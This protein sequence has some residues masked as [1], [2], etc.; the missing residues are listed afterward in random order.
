[1]FV[2]D[3]EKNS[4]RD[5]HTAQTGEQLAAIVQNEQVAV[6]CTRRQCR[7]VLPD[8]ERLLLLRQRQRVLPDNE[9]RRPVLSDTEWLWRELSDNERLR[10][11]ERVLRRHGT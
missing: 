7:R 8:N 9:R 5:G 3:A 4:A 6:L 11:H 10:L 2:D 1:M